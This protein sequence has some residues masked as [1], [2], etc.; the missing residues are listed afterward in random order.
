MIMVVGNF[1]IEGL[2]VI[3][4]FIKKSIEKYGDKVKMEIY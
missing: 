1:M 2:I 3:S 4:L